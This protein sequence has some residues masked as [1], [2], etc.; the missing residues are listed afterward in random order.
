[1]SLDSSDSISLLTTN[2]ATGFLTF[3]PVGFVPR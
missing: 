3:T 1:L 2:Q